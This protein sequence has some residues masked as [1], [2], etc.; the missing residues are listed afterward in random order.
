MQALKQLVADYGSQ[1]PWVLFVALVILPGLGFPAGVLLLLAGVVWGSQPSTCLLALAG[2]LLNVTWTHC[3]AAGLARRRIVRWMGPR[4]QPW[5]DLPRTDLMK[6]AWL[7][8]V[9]PGVPLF[10][11]N[12]ALGA[13]GVPLRLSLLTALPIVALYTCGFVLTGGAI[14]DGRLGLAISGVALL[15]AAAIAMRLIRSRQAK[16]GS[17]AGGGA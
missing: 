5:L 9:T 8:R 12:Y 3:L 4:L 15:A 7:L 11:Q 17:D 6:V 13:L 14:F 16:P 10:L 1:Y 2:I